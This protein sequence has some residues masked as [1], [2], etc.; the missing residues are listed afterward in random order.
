MVITMK[1]RYA[2]RER[3]VTLIELTVALAVAVLMIAV[4]VPSYQSFIANQR[5]KAA[6]Q[7]LYA[8]ML[9]ARA[10][11]I[12]RNA[13]VTVTR[14]GSSWSDGWTI[15]TTNGSGSTVTIR[16]QN[17]FAKVDVA[18]ATASVSFNRTGRA[19]AS[20]MFAVCD[21]DGSADSGRQVSL[22]T[23]GRPSVDVSEGCTS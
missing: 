10:E 1:R 12:K 5:V 8:S 14:S 15:T 4:A 22:D 17:A 18:S 21:H 7:A 13:D 16:T 11:A 20:A 19:S 2:C 9:L 23:M 3:G 6:S